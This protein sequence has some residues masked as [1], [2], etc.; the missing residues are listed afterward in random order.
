[1]VRLRLAY[2]GMHPDRV[3]SLRDRFGSI[4][5]VVAAIERRAIKVPERA[6]E[7]VL[8]DAATRRRELSARGIAAVERAGLPPHL[9]ELPDGPE[10]LFV[11]G[12]LPVRPGVAVV[13]ARRATSYGL[14]LARRY[15]YALA[16]AGWPVVS[17][18]ARGIDGAAHHGV[19]DA[20]GIGV[21]VLGSGI[22]VWYPAEH[23]QLGERLLAAGGAVVS[24]YPPGT[25][26][27]GWRF[28]PRNRII[29]GLAAVVVVVEAT[30]TGGALITAKRAL[31]QGREVFAVPGD[32]DRATST[33]CNL[34]IR[35]GAVPVLDPDDLVEAASLVLGPARPQAALSVDTPVAG[36]IGTI[37]ST[38]DELALASGLSIAQIQE[39]VSRLELAG[40]VA[41]EGDVVRKR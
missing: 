16:E 17:G 31:E 26:P 8:V 15:G 22:D 12:D 37:G 3:A 40:I 36:L 41:R 25:P 29:S 11:K 1:M 4:E 2:A 10:L 30:P 32:V 39:E 27:V 19:L 14:R 38:I 13:G 35:D 7:A 33:G 28:P 20:G 23:R 5:R 24:E 34:L 9:S 6:R 18:L 21:A